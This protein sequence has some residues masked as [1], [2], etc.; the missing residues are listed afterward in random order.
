MCY[1]CDQAAGNGPAGKKSGNRTS[2][3]IL[4]SFIHFGTNWFRHKSLTSAH[5]ML[6]HYAEVKIPMEL[7]AE[8]NITCRSTQVGAEVIP[9]RSYSCRTSIAPKKLRFPRI[10]P[11]GPSKVLELW[12]LLSSYILS[13]NRSTSSLMKKMFCNIVRK[14]DTLI[15]NRDLFEQ[16]T[17]YWNEF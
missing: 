2:A 15:Y 8:I 4:K 12:S 6:L 5:V 13:I 7:G 17:T 3:Q 9:C 11:I 1:Q 16:T 10:G 14:E